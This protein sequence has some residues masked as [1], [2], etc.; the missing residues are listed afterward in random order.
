MLLLPRDSRAYDS[1]PRLFLE[2]NS[3]GE[4][5]GS[6]CVLVKDGAMAAV[7]TPTAAPTIAGPVAAARLEPSMPATAGNS[8]ACAEIAK[9]FSRPKRSLV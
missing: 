5:A 2:N 7:A 1:R 9:V 8:A 4:R 6:R 3:H